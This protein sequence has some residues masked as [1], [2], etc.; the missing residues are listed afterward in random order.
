MHP[1][2]RPLVPPFR[3]MAAALL[4]C[5]GLGPVGLL[6]SSLY[7]GVLMIFLGLLVLRA[8]LWVLR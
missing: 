6:Y 8:K 3:S 4:F 5:V 2:E 1:L 7:G